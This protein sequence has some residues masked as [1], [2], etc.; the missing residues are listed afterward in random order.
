[1]ANE[2]DWFQGKTFTSDWFSNQIPTWS[3]LLKKFE[4]RKINILEIGSYEGRSATFM[5]EYLP[6]STITCIDPFFGDTNE[7][8]TSNMQSYGDRVIKIRSK[9]NPILHDLN[10][11][12]RKYDLIYIDG[13]HRRQPTFSHSVLSWP[14]L[15]IGGIIIWDDYKWKMELP[16]E[17]RPEDAINVFCEAFSQ[18]LNIL[19]RQYQVA[20]EKTQAWPE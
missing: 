17:E 19:H 4:N 14:L 15:K 3:K 8:F 9:A 13:D 1:M 10:E 20:A 18:C 12:E 2:K 5:L 11:A 7:R 6:Y 16:S